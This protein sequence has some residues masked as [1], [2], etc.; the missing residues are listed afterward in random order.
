M[1]VLVC[2]VQKLKAT[3]PL[4]GISPPDG[5]YLRRLWSR[6]Y[7]LKYAFV[8][9]KKAHNPL[10]IIALHNHFNP[11]NG[12]LKRAG[13]HFVGLSVKNGFSKRQQI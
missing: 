13:K 5:F 1:L 2:D 9:L 4:F 3:R 11:V 10:I 8:V 6:F 12:R 7:F